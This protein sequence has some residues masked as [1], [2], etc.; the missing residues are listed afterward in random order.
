MWRYPSRSAASTAAVVSSGGLWKTPSPRAGISTPLF[1]FR[2]GVVAGLMALWSSQVVS[3][4]APAGRRRSLGPGRLA[5]RLRL[6]PLRRRPAGQE[7]Q[8]L[9]GGR[10]GLGGVERHAETLVGVEAQRLVAELDLTDDGVVQTLAARPVEAHVV[11]RP[12]H[13]ELVAAG[14]QLAD[15]VLEVAVVR[16]AAGVRAQV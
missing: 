9:L 7:V 11:R 2:A 14:G 5:A 10:A 8:C 16:V 13:T 4:K 12:A 3:L 15:E 1:S 6:G